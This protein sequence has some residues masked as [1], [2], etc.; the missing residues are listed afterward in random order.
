MSGVPRIGALLLLWL[1]GSSAHAV[2]EIDITEGI[3]GALPIAIAAF[4]GEAYNDSET[5]EEVVRND[6]RRSGL[7]D[8]LESRYF[9]QGG[10]GTSAMNYAAWRKPALKAADRRNYQGQ[11]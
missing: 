9:P 10:N 7:F 4:T 11:G 3:E 1:L 2:L 5:I 6:L 8:V